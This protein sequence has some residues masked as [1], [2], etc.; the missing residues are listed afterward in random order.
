MRMMN[1]KSLIP[2]KNRFPRNQRFSREQ[3]KPISLENL[4]FLE[5]G[6]QQPSNDDNSNCAVSNKQASPLKEDRKERI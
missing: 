4:W 5:I 2:I 1:Y 3:H 6:N